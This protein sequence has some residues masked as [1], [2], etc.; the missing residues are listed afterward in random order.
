M[1][2]AAPSGVNSTSPRITGR[3]SSSSRAY[4]RMKLQAQCQLTGGKIGSGPLATSSPFELCTCSDDGPHRALAAVL[5]EL[6]HGSAHGPGLQHLSTV[7]PRWKLIACIALQVNRSI[8]C[9]LDAFVE[10]EWVA[11]CSLWGCGSHLGGGPRQGG[12]LKN[13]WHWAFRRTIFRAVP[14]LS[15]DR[16]GYLLGN[17]CCWLLR[18]LNILSFF[19]K[20]SEHFSFFLFFF[21]LAVFLKLK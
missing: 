6:T 10:T 20:H 1:T 2:Q 21:F 14:K 7:K 19:C 3:V 4:W 9:L 11:S 18:L 16:L 8:K 5:P 17:S 12:V 13:C 15:E